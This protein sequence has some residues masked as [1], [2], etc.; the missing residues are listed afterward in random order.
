VAVAASLKTDRDPNWNDGALLFASCHPLQLRQEPVQVTAID[1]MSANRPLL[2]RA[3]PDKPLQSAH[4]Q[5]DENPK[6]GAKLMPGDRRNAEQA[7]SILCPGLD[8]SIIGLKRPPPH[9]ICHE[10]S[11]ASLGRKPI[12]KTAM[13]AA[14]RQLRRRA[15]LQEGRAYAELERAWAAC[16]MSERAR[17]KRG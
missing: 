17:F 14:E 7:W 3:D 4:F 10:R 11:V 5:C 12:G 2:Q 8:A 16:S 6:I 9:R 13:T 15:R 1:F